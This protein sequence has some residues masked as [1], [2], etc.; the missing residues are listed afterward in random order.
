MGVSPKG[1][2]KPN[3]VD[4]WWDSFPGNTGNCWYG[5]K[6]PDGARVTSSPGFLPNCSNGK[7]PALSIGLGNVL[8]ELELVGCLVGMQIGDSQSSTPLTCNW[9]ETPKRPT[10]SGSS[11]SSLISSQA[12][13][14]AQGALLNN[15]CASGLAPR[16]CSSLGKPLT[17]LSSLL[18]LGKPKATADRELPETPLPASLSKTPLSNF[19]CTWW[20]NASDDQQ[21]GLVQRIQSFATGAISGS[22][23][24]GFGAGM[25]DSRAVQLFDSRCSTAHAGSYA[26]Y[27]LYG[28]AAPF[29][30]RAAR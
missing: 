22:T 8:N 11:A 23:P 20:R 17:Q 7:N 16:L 28:A 24:Y 13:S 14:P 4:F 2:V 25:S 19:T 1:A 29:L 26:L 3:G 15:I 9:A 12:E 10:G 30:A 18:S 5:N 27:K 21:V 6:G